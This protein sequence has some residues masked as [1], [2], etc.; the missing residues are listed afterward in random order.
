MNHYFNWRHPYQY[1]YK[2]IIWP[3]HS[4]NLIA[5]LGPHYY[6]SHRSHFRMS[7][8]KI[9]A[10]PYFRMFCFWLDWR[11]SFFTHQMIAGSLLLWGQNNHN[12]IGTITFSVLTFHIV[13]ASNLQWSRAW[14]WKRVAP[15]LDRSSWA[16]SARS[17]CW[18]WCGSGR[19]W[20]G[21]SR[22]WTAWSAEALLCK[23]NER[24]RSDDLQGWET[25][26]KKSLEVSPP[27]LNPLVRKQASSAVSG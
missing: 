20:S 10:L 15:F 4:C 16:S 12:E 11:P 1:L 21:S 24:K 25:D 17:A 26:S 3:Q 18:S 23:N 13:G 8:W 7:G 27:W 6:V 19:L 9:K 14:P 22:P 2:N 5:G